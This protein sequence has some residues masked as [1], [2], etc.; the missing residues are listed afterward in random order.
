MLSGTGAVPTWYLQCPGVSRVWALV[1]IAGF[2]WEPRISQVMSGSQCGCS[3]PLFLHTPW[4]NLYPKGTG[5]GILPGFQPRW[6]G[7]RW[8][9]V[10]RLSRPS[11]DSISG[12]LTPTSTGWNVQ[13][14]VCH[15]WPPLGVLPRL[16]ADP[17]PIPPPCAV[18]PVCAPL[19]SPAGDSAVP[20]PPACLC[21]ACAI[22]SMCWLCPSPPETPAGPLPRAVAVGGQPQ[23]ASPLTRSPSSCPEGGGV[24]SQ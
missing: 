20:C 8:Q 2:V 4:G 18:I 21:W 3:A 1:L 11:Q 15:C 7:G 10:V 22:L 9:G 5:M 12:V 24:Q 19:L 13:Q 23:A 16:C 17:R 14:C 6:A